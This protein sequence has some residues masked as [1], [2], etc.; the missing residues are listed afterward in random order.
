MWENHAIPTLTWRGSD[1]NNE[2]MKNSNQM[3][4]LGRN[5]SNMNYTKYETSS[6]FKELRNVKSKD[7]GKVALCT[8]IK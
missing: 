7:E 1:R 2:T 3:V 4:I 8:Y 5:D 6:F